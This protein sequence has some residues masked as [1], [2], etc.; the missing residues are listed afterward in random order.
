MNMLDKIKSAYTASRRE[1]NTET[2]ASL[3]TLLGEIEKESFTSKGR[4]EI[5]DIM[6][7]SKVKKAIDNVNLTLAQI[8]QASDKYASLVAEKSILESFLP[9]QM[10]GSVLYESLNALSKETGV[11]GPKLLGILKQRFPGQYDGREASDIV[12]TML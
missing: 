2:I 10:T 8:T 3:S 11:V 6:V 5:T 1:R 9:T 4:V 12:K 7:T